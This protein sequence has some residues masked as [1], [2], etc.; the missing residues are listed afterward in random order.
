MLPLGNGHINDTY[1][2]NMHTGADK[3]VLQRLNSGVFPRPELVMANVLRVSRHLKAKLTHV[4]S[5]MRT[6]EF[7]P[8]DKGFYWLTDE[9]GAVWRLYSYIDRSFVYE[10]AENR[11]IA[12]EGGRA[13]GDFQSLLADLDPS[14]LHEVLPDFHDMEKRL[15]NFQK[16]AEEDAL[17]RVSSSRPEV[18]FVQSRAAPMSLLVP[19]IQSYMLPSRVTHNDTKISNV[20][21]DQHTF[22]AVCI[23]DL[24][25][26]MAGTVLY[27]FGDAI[28][29]VANTGA[30][31]EKDLSKIGI[32]IDLFRAFTKGYLSKTASFLCE[33]EKSKLA[34]SSLVM[35]FIMGLRF[36]TD[37]LDGD[38]Y[39]RVH[40]KGHNLRRARAQFRL[41]KTMEADLS[42][43][44]DIVNEA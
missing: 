3:Y 4:N 36:L 10:K 1:V 9:T 35:T 29:T 24:D 7:V 13:F 37:Y 27:D 44:E 38:I 14:S 19:L 15:R 2:L 21:F 22:D 32:D 12:K 17:H 8:T 43:M 33:I 23:I 40:T 34:Y 39:Y 25:T 16:S 30:E 42:V 26:V 11:H 18:E 20:L 28:R 31:D 6:L 5:P 41:L